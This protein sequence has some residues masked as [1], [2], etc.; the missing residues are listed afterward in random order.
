MLDLLFLCQR[1]PYP[2]NKG[3]KIRAF[4]ILNHLARR[5]RIHLGCLV[6][7]PADFQHVPVVREL[8]AETHFAALDRGAARRRCLAGLATGRPLSLA[9]FHDPG[10]ARWT[11]SLLARRAP[12][13]V[14]VY[15]SAMAQYLP[16]GLGG[17]AGGVPQGRT[18]MD[19]VDVDSDKWRQYAERRTGVL[20]LPARWLY[21]RESRTLLAFDRRVAARLDLS[22]F[23]SEPEAALFRRLAPESAAKT[24]AVTNGIDADTFSPDRAY[25]RPA[26]LDGPGPVLVFTGT[27]DYWPNVDAVSWFAAEI[28]P[29]IQATRADARFVVVGANP[30]AQ[31]R[32]LANRAGVAV[33]GR[34][35]D[36][37]PYL[38]HADLAVAPVRTA[39]GIQNKVLEAM[40]MAK[41]VVVTP[42]A[43]EGIDAEPGREL[44]V[45]PDRPADFAEAVLGALAQPNGI[46]EAARRRVIADYSWSA[47]LAE[48]DRLLD[49]DIIQQ[50]S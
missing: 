3:E 24:F 26:V 1:I 34:V 50:P 25:P 27:M 9:Y 4:Q 17:R 13:V 49:D 42:Q 32:A 7:D 33:T 29:R 11:G 39:R 21:R 12:S 37:R 46:G 2:P 40:A 48:L 14:F 20:A 15:S 18:I 22:L 43:L 10:L 41:P 31:V 16:D 44:I 23:V 38:A 35:A 30:T 6:D 47:R 19:F 8:C 5:Y 45:A 36:V 28:L